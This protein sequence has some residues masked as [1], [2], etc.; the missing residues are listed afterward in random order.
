M[1]RRKERRR[2]ER[3]RSAAARLSGSAQRSGAYRWRPD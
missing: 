1:V 2:K 3:R